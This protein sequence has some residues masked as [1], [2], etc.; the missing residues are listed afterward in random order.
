MGEVRSFLSKPSSLLGDVMGV[1]VC[2]C[3]GDRGTGNT[4]DLCED[5]L[6]GENMC[7]LGTGDSA[8]EALV[9]LLGVVC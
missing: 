7:V 3:I 1:D 2:D 6:V 5:S 9:S 4:D 8:L